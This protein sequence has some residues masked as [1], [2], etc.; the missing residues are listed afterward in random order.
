MIHQSIQHLLARRQAGTLDPAGEDELARLARR[1][2]VMAAAEQRAAG[3]RATRR[4]IV[5]ACAATVLVAGGAAVLLGRHEPETVATAQ[6]PAAIAAP[7]A[8][9]LPQQQHPTVQ[10]EPLAM[11]AATKQPAKPTS[12]TQRKLAAEPVVTCNS[13]CDADS[14]INEI[15][16]FLSA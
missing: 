4:R 2:E 3:I 14:V 7:A 13:E 10:A 8:E 11:A 12:A 9:L 6:P 16:K 1:D 5:A 15:W